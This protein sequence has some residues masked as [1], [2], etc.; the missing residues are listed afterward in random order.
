MLCTE[1]TFAV[2]AFEW[3]LLVLA[4]YSTF[5]QSRIRISKIKAPA[6]KLKAALSDS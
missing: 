4:A 1:E 2:A 6:K 3:K 5:Q